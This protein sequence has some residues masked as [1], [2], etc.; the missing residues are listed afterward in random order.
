MLGLCPGQGGPHEMVTPT[1]HRA[2]SDTNFFCHYVS[3]LHTLPYDLLG[4]SPLRSF[5]WLLL[6][7]Y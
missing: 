6:F 2:V 1:L 7:Y 3:Q 4:H 5:K